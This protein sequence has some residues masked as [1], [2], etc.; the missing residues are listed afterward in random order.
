MVYLL[1]FISIFVFIFSYLKFNKIMN[2]PIEIKYDYSKSDWIIPIGFIVFSFLV[3]FGID[4]GI[5]SFC[6]SLDTNNTVILWFVLFIK[7]GF[8]YP[9]LCVG[10]S[11]AFGHFIESFNLDYLELYSVF[12]P[13][14]CFTVLIMCSCIKMLYIINC[15]GSSFLE[16]EDFNNRILMWLI[17]VIG[18]WFGFGFRCEGRIVR[19]KNKMLRKNMYNCIK[20]DAYIRRNYIDFWGPII[21]CLIFGGLVIFFAD[22]YE[23]ISYM[24]F[25]MALSFVFAALLSI[26]KYKIIYNPALFISKKSLKRLINNKT[27][28]IHFERLICEKDGNYI[29]VHRTPVIYANHEKDDDFIKL[30]DEFDVE[31]YKKNKAIDY[32][33]IV[34]ELVEKIHKQDNYIFAENGRCIAIQREKASECN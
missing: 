20:T 27:K 24:I 26:F 34:S 19:E 31:I 16:T 11:V 23:I 4:L 22:V 7:N 8:L 9:V 33:K 28:E 21:V 1:G 13:K 30:F 5:T 15:G 32:E 17:T 18:I 29:K 2:S 6:D 12:V 10:M 25:I 3:A 14:F